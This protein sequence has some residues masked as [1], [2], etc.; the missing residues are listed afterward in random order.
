VSRGRRG[1]EAP[2][3]HPVSLRRAAV[4]ILPLRDGDPSAPTPFVPTEESSPA[5]ILGC[6]ETLGIPWRRVLLGEIA[7]E[8]KLRGYLVDVEAECP[9][10]SALTILSLSALRSWRVR[11]RVETLTS[12]ARTS[13]RGARKKL[14]GFL[15][16]LIGQES[17]DSE[18]LARHCRF[19]YERILLLQR[20]RRA[21]A[22]SCGTM[23][24]RL[25]FVCSTARCAFEDA[26]WA[27][28]E[29]DSPRRGYR[30]EAAVRKVRDEGFLVP[31]A[32]TEA[33]SLAELRRIVFA[34]SRLRRRDPARNRPDSNSST[35]LQQAVSPTHS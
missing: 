32:R 21:A 15:R 33:R 18:A 28:R 27:L 29:E 24:E 14:Q 26:A 8:Q 20:V 3:W 17:P 25:A 23:A 30:M 4:T 11:D 19:A 34:S 1:L 10:E 31:R 12:Q 6:A 2:V 5:E 13:V 9:L 22:R 16:R 7:A 35:L